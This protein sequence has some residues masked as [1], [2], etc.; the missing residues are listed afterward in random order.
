MGDYYNTLKL[1]AD[2]LT[3]RRYKNRLDNE[4]YYQHIRKLDQWY[5]HYINLKVIKQNEGVK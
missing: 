2:A 4:L 5:S 3:E 1:Y